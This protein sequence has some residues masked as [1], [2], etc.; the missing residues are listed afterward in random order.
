MTLALVTGFLSLM[1]ENMPGGG[2][3]PH[4]FDILEQ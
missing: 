3:N 1:T 2:A 4:P